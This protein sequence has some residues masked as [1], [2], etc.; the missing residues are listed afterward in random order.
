M[1]VPRGGCAEEI[2]GAAAAILLR[3][4][5]GVTE[6][7]GEQWAPRTKEDDEDETGDEGRLL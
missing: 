7:D 4:W 2:T 1:S 6:G 3:A 5:V